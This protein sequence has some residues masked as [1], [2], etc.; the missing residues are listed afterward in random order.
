MPPRGEEDLP[1]PSANLD[2]R[3][4]PITEEGGPW[5]RVHGAERHPVFFGKTG[6]GR[7][8]DPL[9]EY[10]V[11]YAAEDTFDAFVEF[12]GRAPGRNVVSRQAL[13]GRP[14]SRI[15]PHHGPSRL[16]DLSGG[17][18]AKIGATAAISSGFYE[19]AQAWSRA[20]HDHPDAPDG[21]RY[22]LKHDPSRLGVALF[23]RGGSD[24]LRTERVG[25]L[26]DAEHE[27]VLVA[28]LKEYGF[29]LISGPTPFQGGGSNRNG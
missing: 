21:I 11:L 29:G 2:S 8:D 7:F 25:T 26:I 23:D 3:G 5:V 19:K 12:F 17:G 28:I 9:G 1:P 15:A 16:A 24:A 10:G 20:L 13:A 14:L 4:L 6:E 22:R 18:L 27:K